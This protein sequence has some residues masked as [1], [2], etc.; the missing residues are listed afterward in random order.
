MIHDPVDTHAANWFRDAL[1]DD[2]PSDLYENA[3]CG[4]VSILPTGQVIKANR[5]FLVWTGHTSQSLYAL[6]LQDLLP[7]GD[8]IF[9][10]THFA[11]SLSLQGSVREIAVELKCV[12]GQRLPVLLNAILVADD[13]G[14]P[15]V[16]RLAVFDARERRAYEEELL[17]ERRRA[18]IESERARSLASTLQR[19]LLPPSTPTIPGLDVGGAY[20]PAGDG[21]EVG[22]DFYDVFETASGAWGIVIGDVCGKGASA[23]VLTALARYT[24]RA[25]AV[26]SESPSAVLAGLHDAM[27]LDHADGFLTAIYVTATVDP[28]D[29]RLR[30]AI[31]GHH[32]PLLLDADGQARPVGRPGHLLGMLGPPKLHDVDLVLDAGS[33][34][35]MTTDGV[36][37]ARRSDGEFFG[38]DRLQSLLARQ[39]GLDA[40]EL[41]EAV[42]NEAISFQDGTT[43]DDIA[44]VALRPSP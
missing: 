26:R 6:R 25:G 10:E 24:I 34:L 21:S 22:G 11:P 32:P 20:R 17:A 1:V 37:E 35:V 38:E 19:T 13:N 3:P 41:A 15:M 23:A 43:R 8:R 16:I 2:D 44:V 12:G 5:T 4:Y 29:V 31:A 36:I 14:D 42:A 18:Q 33:S 27:V 39:R 9:Y 30:M 40:Q 28:P 7:P